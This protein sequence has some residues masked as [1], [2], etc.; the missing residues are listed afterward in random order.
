MKLLYDVIR[1]LTACI[2]GNSSAGL[3]APLRPADYG[4]WD[5]LPVRDSPSVISGE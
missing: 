5:Y 3:Q 4:R 2:F 1:I